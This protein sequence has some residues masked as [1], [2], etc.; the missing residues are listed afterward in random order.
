MPRLESD[1]EK[2]SSFEPPATPVKAWSYSV[3]SAAMALGC[4]LLVFSDS[5]W[6]VQRWILGVG[7]LF[8]AY[9]GFVFAR[10]ANTRRPVS[11]ETRGLWIDAP[12]SRKL[13]GWDSIESVSMLPMSSQKFNVI[14]L[15]DT[16]SLIEQYDAAEAR[17]LVNQENVIGG[18]AAALGFGAKSAPNL[19]TLFAS[20]RK[21]YG[22]EIWISPHDRD[23]DADAFDKLLKAWWAKH[24][25]DKAQ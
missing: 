22:G 4:A 11:F 16:Q 12:T 3:L 25:T 5:A 10:S 1:P 19:A 15:K 21:T 17:A 7:V 14:A 9:C 8:F 2:V 13:V 23:R 20:R 24:R 6:I 18:L